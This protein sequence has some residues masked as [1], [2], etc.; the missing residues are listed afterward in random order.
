MDSRRVSSR[1]RLVGTTYSI[2]PLRYSCFFLSKIASAL[3][4]ERQNTP[5]ELQDCGG[6]KKQYAGDREG[7]GTF[8]VSIAVAVSV[9]QR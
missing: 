7:V 4:Q 6:Q 2:P 5:L 3:L 1:N 8:F 9:S